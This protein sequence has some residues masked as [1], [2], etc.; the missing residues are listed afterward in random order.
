MQISVFLLL[1]DK[2]I[3]IQCS[4]IYFQTHDVL[5]ISFTLRLWEPQLNILYM[6][7]SQKKNII[8]L[9]KLLKVKTGS[10]AAFF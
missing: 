8:A 2:I 4:Q 6:S 9:N 3:N 7:S 1:T 10:I 5:H